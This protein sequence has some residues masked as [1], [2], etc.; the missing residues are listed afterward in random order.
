MEFFFFRLPFTC[1]ECYFFVHTLLHRSCPFQKQFIKDALH[2]V[3]SSRL[4]TLR[5]MTAKLFTQ[6]PCQV[7]S[8]TTSVSNC[9]CYHPP[10]HAYP[11]VKH[12]NSIYIR[13]MGDS[14]NR[15]VSVKRTYSQ[16][17]S[18]TK[19]KQ[20][21]ATSS[22]KPVQP[23]KKPNTSRRRSRTNRLRTSSGS[24]R[25]PVQTS[26]RRRRTVKSRSY[27]RRFTRRR[28]VTSRRRRSRDK[29]EVKETSGE[30]TPNAITNLQR[31]LRSPRAVKLECLCRT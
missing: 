11:E 3:S 21:A 30:T 31:S 2:S 23:V 14:G 12:A 24:D 25:K 29:R 5:G 22:T 27:R 13:V 28:R 15:L 20:A 19:P 17:V 16:A 1:T 6:G 8:V 26:Q 7:C 9:Q 10:F 4:K 18:Q